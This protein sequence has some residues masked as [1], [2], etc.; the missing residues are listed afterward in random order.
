VADLATHPRPAPGSRVILIVDD[1]LAIGDLVEELL[2]GEGYAVGLLNSRR[3]E[4]A[5]DA[6]GRLR[7]D[8]VLLDGDVRGGYGMSWADAAWMRTQTPPVPVVM[9]SAE[10]GA[11]DEAKMNLS[12]RSQAAGFWSVLPKQFEIDDLLAVVALAVGQSPF[13]QES[14]D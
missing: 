5:Q 6:V 13:R 11:T 9:F 7:P 8:C 3:E 2:T 1:D 12:E 10:R 14:T 4:S